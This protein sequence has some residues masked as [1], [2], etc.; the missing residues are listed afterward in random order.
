MAK[1]S[2]IVSDETDRA[3]RMFLAAQQLKDKWSKKGAISDFT[4]EAVKKYLF[5]LTVSQVKERNQK[6]NQ[7]ELMDLIDH[8]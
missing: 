1:W 5:E 7:N 6:F 8:L 4:E 3:L 2:I